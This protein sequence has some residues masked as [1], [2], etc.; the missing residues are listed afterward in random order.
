MWPLDKAL[1][2]NAEFRYSTLVFNE[3]FDGNYLLAGKNVQYPALAIA[4]D[5]TFKPAPEYVKEKREK[6]QSKLD[7]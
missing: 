6:K 2:M 7:L 3:I 1:K 5:T 4:Q